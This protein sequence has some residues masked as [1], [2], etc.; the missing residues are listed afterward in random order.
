MVNILQKPT[1]KINLSN[2]SVDVKKLESQDQFANESLDFAI[3][4]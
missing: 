2:V 3:K 4:T 1:L